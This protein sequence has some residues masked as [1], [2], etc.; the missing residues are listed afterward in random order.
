[1]GVSQVVVR[2][3]A[4]LDGR[5]ANRCAPRRP[6]MAAARWLRSGRRGGGC[7][8]RARS[9]VMLHRRRALAVAWPVHITGA[10]PS[11]IPHLCE[12]VRFLRARSPL[13]FG[14]H[15][16]RSNTRVTPSAV[17]RPGKAGPKG[18][19][20]EVTNGKSGGSPDSPH[21][22]R[23]EGRFRGLPRP[24]AHLPCRARGTFNQFSRAFSAVR[25][26][27]WCDR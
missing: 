7:G 5:Y 6:A 3:F 26:R 2:C 13:R 9:F 21:P 23:R 22:S 19:R 16:A 24:H 17:V 8:S 27:R 12:T 20:F 25:S 14:V 18:R 4:L 10:R 11:S 1:M 15:G